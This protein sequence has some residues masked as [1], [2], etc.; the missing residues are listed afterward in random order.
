MKCMKN[1]GFRNL[2]SE[3]TLEQGLK[4]LG[5]GAWSEKIVFRRW[6]DTEVL[7]EIK[8]NEIWIV[9]RVFIGSS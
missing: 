4:S 2:T 9:T 6:K 7:R 5:K 3:E 8:E 1:E